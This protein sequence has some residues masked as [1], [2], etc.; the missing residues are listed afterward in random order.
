MTCDSSYLS[1]RPHFLLPRTFATQ[2]TNGENQSDAE[3]SFSIS[4]SLSLVI[5]LA[6]SYVHFGTSNLEVQLS[7]KRCLWWLGQNAEKGKCPMSESILVDKH[8]YPIP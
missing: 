7:W 1:N 6:R 5:P 3:F 8:M 4:L 2:I